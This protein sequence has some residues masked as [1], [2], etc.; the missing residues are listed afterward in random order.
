MKAGFGNPSQGTF[1]VI[2]GL[3]L[4]PAGE[5]EDILNVN[6][7]STASYNKQLLTIMQGEGK[8]TTR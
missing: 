5:G 6:E 4:D 2:Q 1:T 3:L 7:D 8:E